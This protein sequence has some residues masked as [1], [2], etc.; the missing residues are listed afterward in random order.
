MVEATL[1][2]ISRGLLAGFD[3]AHRASVSA[4]A[5]ADT[6]LGINRVNI[7]FLYSSGGAFALA[8]A[9]SYADIC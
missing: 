3:S 8:C 9:A 6:D 1:F 7:A 2:P 5:A 4:S